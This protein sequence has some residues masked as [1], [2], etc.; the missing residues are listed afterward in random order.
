MG[1]FNTIRFLGQVVPFFNARLQG[2]YKLGRSAKDNPKKLAVVTG[3]VAL[4][5]IAL[6]LGYEDD[7]DWKRRED[8]DR[9]GFWFFKF[10]GVE[11]RIPKPFE[12]GAAASLAE[13]SVEYLINDEMTG[14]RFR[15]VVGAL[16]MNNLSMNPVPQ[17]VKPII[18]LYAN[19]DSFTGR[20]I[21]SMSMERLEKTM[22]FNSNTSMPARGLLRQGRTHLPASH[23]YAP[24]VRSSHARQALSYYGNPPQPSS[25]ARVAPARARC[26]R[27]GH[28]RSCDP[29]LVSI[30]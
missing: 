18:D 16:A 20:P 10:G 7:E 3:A 22:R 28:S 6:M 26:S 4:A 11:Y 8:W 19:K 13:R 5:S 21:E 15:K 1:S 24:L 12:V 23:F 25:G 9:D 2:M 17:A 14:E 29:A 30:S 27:R